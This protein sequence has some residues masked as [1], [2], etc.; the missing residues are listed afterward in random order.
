MKTNLRTSRSH[1]RLASLAALATLVAAPALPAAARTASGAA[2]A[3]SLPQEMTQGSIHYLTGGTSSDE[4]SA[5][6]EAMQSYPLAIEL[7]EKQASSKHDAY[8]ADAQIRITDN[9]G[10]SIFSA[11]AKGPFMLVQLPP[12]RYSLSAT[13][14]HHTLTRSDV[15]IELGKTARE[16]FVFPAGTG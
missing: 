14:N 16:T 4:A 5:F 15:M 1:L 11:R 10:K 2:T 9:A 8:T 12:G 6:K 7:A 13:L 3:V